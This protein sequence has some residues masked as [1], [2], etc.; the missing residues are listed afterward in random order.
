MTLNP[1]VDRLVKVQGLAVGEHSKCETLSRTPGGK[2]INV[3]K[4]LA[5][6]GVK[7]LATGFL[8]RANRTVF[9]EVF[10]SQM[11]Q[12]FFITLDGSTRENLT[13]VDYD[14]DAEIHLRDKGLA[15]GEKDFANIEKTLSET[16][17][18]NDTVIFSGSLPPGITPDDQAK[19]V[20]L[21]SQTGG[22][23]IAD[24]SGEALAAIVKLPIS[25]IKPNVDE[26]CELLDVKWTN[27]H[28]LLTAAEPVLK[29]VENILLSHG[30][31]GAYLISKDNV[32]FAPTPEV[33]VINTVGCGDTLLGAFAGA[34]TLGET[35]Q[36][37][38]AI[39]VAT[40]AASAANKASAVFDK[41]LAEKLIKQTEIQTI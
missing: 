3:S 1:A 26:L 16:I 5:A 2:G 18:P 34:T 38:L 24:T 19:L 23:V 6:M 35:P 40:A 31:K 41:A 12:D 20:S 25:L 8:G 10:T 15:V 32:F 39:A 14:T 36:Q 30:S 28:S 27:I 21:A 11:V 7:S 9:D 4:V 33:D 29:N 37:S 17:Q 13:L 22:K